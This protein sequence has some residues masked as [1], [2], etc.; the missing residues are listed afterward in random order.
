MSSIFSKGES[1]LKELL[2][3]LQAVYRL[4]PAVTEDLLVLPF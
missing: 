3:S 4:A 2:I 1:P